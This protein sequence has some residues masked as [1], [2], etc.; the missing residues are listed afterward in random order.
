MYAVLHIMEGV[1]I[2]FRALATAT[3]VFVGLVLWVLL[4]LAITLV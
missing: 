4:L 2:W 3:K 1:V